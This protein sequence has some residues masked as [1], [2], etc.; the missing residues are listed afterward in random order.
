MGAGGGGRRGDCGASAAAGDG[1][2]NAGLPRGAAAVEQIATVIRP[3]NI[4]SQTRLFGVLGHP[5]GHSLSPAMQNAAIAELGLNAVYLAFDV[6]PD[7][8]PAA[9]DGL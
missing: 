1:C 9:L 5:V 7:R 6:A 2:K 3:N 4:N 8:L